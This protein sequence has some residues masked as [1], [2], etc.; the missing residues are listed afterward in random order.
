MCGFLLIF[1]FNSGI[2]IL[3]RCIRA[4]TGLWIVGKSWWIEAH[5]R[6]GLLLET[7]KFSTGIQGRKICISYSIKTFEPFPISD[8]L[9][10]SY[11]PRVTRSVCNL[12]FSKEGTTRNP[13]FN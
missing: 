11:Q 9:V 13:V 1:W 4:L 2:E 8:T 10:I 6:A 7:N 12:A 5:I 3:I